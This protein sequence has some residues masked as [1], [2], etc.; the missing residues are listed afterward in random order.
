[1]GAGG[2]IVPPKSYFPKIM[3]VCAKYDIFMI[4]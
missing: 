4:D 2:V 1:M 3:E